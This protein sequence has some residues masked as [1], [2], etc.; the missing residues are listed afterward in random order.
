MYKELAKQLLISIFIFLIGPP[1]AVAQQN[2]I[3]D[4]ST[5]YAIV[6]AKEKG[7]HLIFSTD[8]IVYHADKDYTVVR[9]A[10][11]A[12]FSTPKDSWKY[13]LRGFLFTEMPSGGLIWRKYRGLFYYQDR[14]DKPLKV[15]NKNPAAFNKLVDGGDTPYFQFVTDYT[16]YVY[17]DNSTKIFRTKTSGEDWVTMGDMT[18]VNTGPGTKGFI[19]NMHFVSEEIG[20]A[21][22]QMHE[23]GPYS[24]LSVNEFMGNRI[25]RTDDAGRTWQVVKMDHGFGSRYLIGD[26]YWYSTDGEKNVSMYAYGDSIIYD[27]TDGGENFISRQIVNHKQH[28]NKA[29]HHAP[30]VVIDANNYKPFKV[31]FIDLPTVAGK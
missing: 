18:E 9:K 13:L 1:Q 4:R 3:R 30:S 14:I 5:R 24:E 6:P 19:R 8:K 11:S 26:I 31:Y 25:V 15:V 2:I 10:T 12:E 16:G 23:L 20:F 22:L 28:W 17:L 7:S 27:S 29:A 21:W